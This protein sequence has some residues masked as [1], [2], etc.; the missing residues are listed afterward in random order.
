MNSFA[1][2]VSTPFKAVNFVHVEAHTRDDARTDA[3]SVVLSEFGR[4]C[5]IKGRP[6][7]VDPKLQ[8]TFPST[9]Y[10][11][12]RYSKTIRIV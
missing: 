5:H 11:W 8:D 9:K 4:G 10:D 6:I 3:V 7:T 12:A 1:I 2:Q